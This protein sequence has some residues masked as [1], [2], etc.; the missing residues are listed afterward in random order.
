MVSVLFA[1]SSAITPVAPALAPAVREAEKAESEAP[2]AM[3]SEPPP[4]PPTASV[5]PSTLSVVESPLSVSVPAPP[6]CEPSAS[7]PETS[8]ESPPCSVS[9]CAPATPIVQSPPTEN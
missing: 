3:C 2:S 8:A 4:P 6:L 9:E 5:A 1:P 7:A